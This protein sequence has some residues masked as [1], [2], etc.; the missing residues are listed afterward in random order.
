MVFAD[1]TIYAQNAETLVER[2]SDP[3][4]GPTLRSGRPE[5]PHTDAITARIRLLAPTNVSEAWQ[6]L[7]S[8]DEILHF[9]LNEI[10]DKKDP[11]PSDDPALGRLKESI[12]KFYLAT[13]DALGHSGR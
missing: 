3:L 10:Y 9:K 4:Y 8:A 1:A 11:M 12:D 6:E 13:R 5:L 7:I 2:I